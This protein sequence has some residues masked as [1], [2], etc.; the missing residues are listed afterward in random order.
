[1]RRRAFTML[2]PA[3][4]AL[5]LSG[6]SG[7]DGTLGP[8]QST[9]RVGALGASTDNLNPLMANGQ[10]DYIAI[11]HLYETLVELRDGV[12]TP[13][14]AQSVTP[15][16]G[17]TRW[18]IVLRDDAILAGA[19]TTARPVRAADAAYSLSLLSDPSRSPGYASF[20]QDMDAA[21]IEVVDD[22]TLVVPLTRPRADFLSTVLAFASFIVPEGFE[23]WTAPVGSGPYELEAYEPGSR[24]VLKARQD[25]RGGTPAITRLEISVINDPQTRMNALKSGEI[26]VATRLD[27][28]I[29]K[30]E[31]ANPDIIIHRGSTADA[32]VLGFEMNVK[33]PPF[34]D[35]SVR[36]AVKLAIDRQEMVST[37]LFGEGQVGNDLVGLG[38]EGYASDIPQRE[39]DPSRACELFAQAGVT[40]ISIRAA[41]IAPGLT[42]AAKLLV[43]QLAATGVTATVEPVE[44]DAFFA[45]MEV[46]LSTPM[47]VAYYLN[48]DAGAYLGS[49]SGSTGF[50]NISGYAPA[51]F[52]E[53]LARAQSTLDAEARAELFGQAQRKIWE[54]GGTVLWGYQTV[55]DASIP[56]L[57]DMGLAQGIPVF[58]RASL[59]RS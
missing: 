3:L 23:D 26:D 42:S 33:A 28:V 56:G 39:H 24:I 46:V 11:R 27:P 54:E 35:P 8:S 15:N 16:E 7:R 52:D 49:F 29:V 53:L 30:A 17:A 34:D 14:V 21:S 20:Y 45:D 40:Q 57:K 9:L 10:A 2:A 5:A 43:D 6:C 31:E 37:V 25:H 47:Q 51:E 12:V 32:Q 50:F 13:V 1:M 4:T 19:G 38:L 36:E 44:A 48:R 58:D 59:S 18:T 41:E 22:R 55:L